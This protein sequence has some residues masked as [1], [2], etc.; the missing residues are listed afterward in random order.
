MTTEQ[1]MAAERY[2]KSCENDYFTGS[3]NESYIRNDLQT[4]KAS[5]TYSTM[6]SSGRQ[7]NHLSQKKQFYY[8]DFDNTEGTVD[9]LLRTLPKTHALFSRCEK[10]KKELTKLR[11]LVRNF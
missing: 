5:D 8:D 11:E 6:G 4:R 10:L 2:I 7:T 3:F 1:L 9:G